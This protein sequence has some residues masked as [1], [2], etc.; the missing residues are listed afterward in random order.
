[1]KDDGKIHTHTDHEIGMTMGDTT[2]AQLDD[3]TWR[4]TCPIGTLFG[5]EVHGECRG[6]GATREAALVEL[7]L[8]R[9]NLNDSLWY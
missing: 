3:G 2:V 7:A 1:M 8:D 5:C 9:K 4:A 6:V